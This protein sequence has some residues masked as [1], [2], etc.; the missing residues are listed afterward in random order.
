MGA[1]STD[2]AQVVADLI[3]SNHYQLAYYRAA[4]MA[5]KDNPRE[6][7]A[8]F[9]FQHVLAAQLS[10]K[11]AIII[12]GLITQMQ[13]STGFSTG[14][15]ADM[16]RGFALHLIRTGQI[17]DVREHLIRSAK[18][19]NASDHNRMAML[20]MA[21]GRMYYFLGSIGQAYSRLTDAYSTLDRLG[22]AAD[23]QWKQNVVFH[24][25]FAQTAGRYPLKLRWNSYKEILHDKSWV[26]RGRATLLMLF[27]RLGI[28]IDHLLVDSR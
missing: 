13:D 14:M 28:K 27:G 16:E 1:P 3:S 25:F 10:N 11:D 24:L 5:L 15:Q 6:L 9:W 8:H 23:A 18:L 12:D 2:P 17:E 4:E 7:N 22:N 19:T 21:Y 20:Y 26:R